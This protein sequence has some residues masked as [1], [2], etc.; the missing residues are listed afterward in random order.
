EG[1]RLLNSSEGLGSHLTLTHQASSQRKT[2]TA[3]TAV[4]AENASRMPISGS[5]AD[6]GRPRTMTSSIALTRWRSGNTCE[7]DCS[8]D[9]APS[10]GKNAPDRNAIGSTMRF[11]TALAASGV[12]LNAPASRPSERNASVPTTT[13]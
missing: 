1:E 13:S 7:I 3:I 9:G 12:L 6:G 11:A 8:H 5:T 2:A 4:T 10:S